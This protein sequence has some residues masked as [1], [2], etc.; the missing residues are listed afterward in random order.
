MHED[1]IK[2]LALMAIHKDIRFE[3]DDVIDQFSPETRH[4]FRFK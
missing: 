2:A 4:R 3:Y 1:R